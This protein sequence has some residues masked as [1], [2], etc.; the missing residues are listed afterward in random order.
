MRDMLS[1]NPGEKK[2][3]ITA[4]FVPMYYL[5]FNRTGLPGYLPGEAAS[6]TPML[7]AWCL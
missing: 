7:S 5:F 3:R 2:A 6:Q 4:G 1:Q